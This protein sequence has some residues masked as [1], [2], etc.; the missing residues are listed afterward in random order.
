MKTKFTNLKV[1]ILVIFCFSGIYV[2]AQSPIKVACV[3]TSITYGMTISNPEQNSYPAQL[4]Q[5]LGSKYEV[6]NF[7]VSGTTLLQRGGDPYRNKDAYRQ[8]ISYQPNIVI[9]EFGANDSKTSNRPYWGDF[10]K[11]YLD[12]INSY[13]NLPSKPRVILSIPTRCYL[14]DPNDISNDVMRNNFV[15]IIEKLVYEKNLEVI[16]LYDLWDNNFDGTVMPD[17]LHPSSIGAGI[18]AEKVY[19]YIT[20]SS[21]TEQSNVNFPLHAV[22]TFNYHGYKGYRYLDNGVEYMLVFP[23]KH[24]KGNPWIWRARFWG[25]EPQTELDLLERGFT[26]AYCDVADLYGAPVAV[27]RWNRFYTLAVEGGLNAKTVLEGMSR[28]GLIIFN[29]AATNTEKVAAIYADAPVMDFKTWPIGQGGQRSDGDV[30]VLLRAYGFTSEQEAIKWDKNPIDHAKVLANANIPMINVVGDADDVVPVMT[31]TAVFEERL[32][33][34][35]YKLDVIHKPGI[36]HHPHSLSNPS[37]IVRFILRA[38]CQGENMCAHPICGNEYRTGAGWRVGD[39]HKVSEEINT[40]IKGRNLDILFLGNSITQGLGGNHRWLVNYKPGLSVAN[41]ILSGLDWESAGISGDRTQ[42]VLWR[43]SQGAYELGNPKT[44]EIAIGINNLVSGKDVPQEVAEG[45][46]AIALESR[47]RFPKANIILLGIFPSGLNPSDDV[48]LKCNAIH[49]FLSEYDWGNIRYINPTTWFVNNDGMLRTECYGGDYLHFTDKGYE[50]WCNNLKE[51]I[52]NPQLTGSFSISNTDGGRSASLK[53]R[54]ADNI[55]LFNGWITTGYI[56]NWDG[57]SNM[58]AEDIASNFISVGT[59]I[60]GNIAKLGKTG[61]L[62]STTFEW[63]NAE[64]IGN[65]PFIA[66]IGNGT[67]IKDAT[68]L[69]VIKFN[70]SGTELKCKNADKKSINISAALDKDHI[71]PGLGSIIEDSGIKYLK[72][73]PFKYPLGIELSE[74]SNIKISAKNGAIQINDIMLESIITITDISGKIYKRVI[75]NGPAVEIKATSKGI[76]IVSIQDNNNKQVYLTQK[77]SIN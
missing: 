55:A 62:K 72:L 60:G 74:S 47:K 30:E 12:L 61:I 35:G 19:A 42:H 37:D 53:M 65:A 43:V 34:N 64:V 50:V 28:G 15:P 4:Q 33:K 54:T 9:L 26:V 75:T 22:S 49:D 66:L 41:R 58:S 23:Y 10:E 44:V 32:K 56:K 45:I 14:T 1:L 17:R 73:A 8:S 3:G 18:V 48:R 29:W 71:I 57:V 16:N 46:R 20:A 40:V 39:W 36:G 11:D 27:E 63:K 7:G 77:T 5:Y 51:I 6:K 52:D 70:I 38:T 69:A 68:S 76:Y 67:S 25:H 13:L 2:L 59:T 24:A 31:N 21:S